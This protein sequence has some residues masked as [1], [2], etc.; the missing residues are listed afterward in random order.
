MAAVQFN[1]EIEVRLKPG[2]TSEQVKQAAQPLVECGVWSGN[3]FCALEPCA[4]VVVWH[5]PDEAVA[6]VLVNAIVSQG[7]VDVI[8][9]LERFGSN[10]APLSAEPFTV[11]CHTSG[12]PNPKGHHT[13]RVFGASLEQARARAVELARHEVAHALSK[14]LAVTGVPAGSSLASWDAGAVQSLLVDQDEGGESSALVVATASLSRMDVED[15]GI[16]MQMI[17]ALGA[18]AARADGGVAVL[19][20]ADAPRAEVPRDED[21]AVSRLGDGVWEQAEGPLTGRGHEMWFRCARTGAWAYVCV[22]EGKVASVEIHKS[23]AP[24]N[25]NRK[26]A[27]RG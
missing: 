3:V 26:E 20:N 9:A 7:G 23:E 12:G 2:V 14:L 8:E 5:S 15:R 6:G 10:I 4:P 11:E 24:E 13:S 1:A 17:Q 21:L 22:D 19:R 18:L 25:R 16:A 27:Q